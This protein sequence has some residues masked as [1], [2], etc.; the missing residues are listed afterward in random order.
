MYRLY[1][2][3]SLEAVKNMKG[4]RGK[5]AA[6]AGHAYL[7][8]F[9]NAR[10]RFPKAAG[11]YLDDQRAFKI[12]L[13]VPTA[14]ELRKLQANYADICGHAL[15]TDAAL[16]VFDEPTTTCLGLGPIH[17][18]QIGSDLRALPVLT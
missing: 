5:L 18:D 4:S 13:A 17:I 10:E 3:F 12:A 15:I 6:Q 16:T 1:C 11:S 2:I 8:S 7:H 14:I 9:M